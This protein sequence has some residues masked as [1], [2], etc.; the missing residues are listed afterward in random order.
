MRSRTGLRWGDN[1]EW[2]VCPGIA[3]QERETWET[4]GDALA[5]SGGCLWVPQ[6]KGPEFGDHTYTRDVSTCKE[7]GSGDGEGKGRRY[8]HEEPSCPRYL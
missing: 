3:E 2:S 5:A 4:F 6:T 7:V 8:I 1:P